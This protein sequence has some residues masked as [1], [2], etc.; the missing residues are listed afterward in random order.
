MKSSKESKQIYNTLSAFA[1]SLPY[2]IYEE[3]TFEVQST[4]FPCKLDE[5][6][7]LTMS[8]IPSYT[9][10]KFLTIILDSFNKTRNIKLPCFNIRKMCK[11]N[12]F[13]DIEELSYEC[14][15][16]LCR[17][18]EVDLIEYDS[19][20]NNELYDVYDIFNC[21]EE[22]FNR[23]TEIFNETGFNPDM[24]SL[25]ET[26]DTS[27][28]I[29]VN[30]DRESFQCSIQIFIEAAPYA[31]FN[32]DELGIEL[33]NRSILADYYYINTFLIFGTYEG[34]KGYLLSID[35]GCPYEPYFENEAPLASIDFAALGVI[36][37]EIKNE[38]FYV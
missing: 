6:C 26:L 14:A 7:H 29:L 24:D 5:E 3:G 27:E 9:R 4:I 25:A 1:R 32:M 22:H 8:I 33:C 16:S 19:S 15:E 30:G 36:I 35:W 28:Y 2:V 20:I 37:Y 11:E 34:K 31:I 23:I 21:T 12:G 38:E 18:L 17:A 13:E 10:L